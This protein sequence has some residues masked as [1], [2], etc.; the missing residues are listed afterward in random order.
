MARPTGSSNKSKASASLKAIFM[1][2]TR[3]FDSSQ[4]RLLSC[5]ELFPM[6][7]GF[8]DDSTWR[9]A[10]VCCLQG[11]AAEVSPKSPMTVTEFWPVS[12]DRFPT[13]SSLV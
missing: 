13:P 5:G 6:I 7:P 12:R 4:A 3:D 9:H 2:A 1:K 11:A 8:N 10:R